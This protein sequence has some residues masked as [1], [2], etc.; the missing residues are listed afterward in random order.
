M[1]QTF[2]SRVGWIRCFE[3]EV[4]QRVVVGTYDRLL[5]PWLPESREQTGRGPEQDRSFRNRFLVTSFT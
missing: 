5:I 1:V 4:M 2:P 3:S